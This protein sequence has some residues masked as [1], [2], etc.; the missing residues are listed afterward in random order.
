VYYP[1]FRQRVLFQVLIESSPTH[2]PFLTASIQP[3]SGVSQ[4]YLVKHHHAAIV[5]T[6]TVVLNVPSQFSLKRLPPFFCF[7]KV[8][9][10]LQPLVH[11]L[12]FAGELLTAGL[13]SNLE[14]AFA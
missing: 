13:A 8:S 5:L 12:A 3:F 1:R 7:H 14:S 6:N 9:D 2:L 11:L 4:R 10:G